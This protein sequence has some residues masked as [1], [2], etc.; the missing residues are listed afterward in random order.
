MMGG[1]NTPEQTEENKAVFDSLMLNGSQSTILVSSSIMDGKESVMT[2][3]PIMTKI[4]ESDEIIQF[5]LAL[6]FGNGLVDFT[7]T[8]NSDGSIL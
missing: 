1:E 6:N 3:N 8:L 7:I 4:T 2:Y 5:T